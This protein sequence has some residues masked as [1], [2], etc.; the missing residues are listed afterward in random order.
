MKVVSLN[1][2]LPRDVRWRGKTTRTSIFKEAVNDRRRVSHLNV[3]GDQQSD[4]Q[5]H[6][7][8]DK[9]IYVYPSEHYAF[10]K[11]ELPGVDLPWGAFGE[12]LTTEGFVEPEVR[13]G[14][15]WK[16]GTAELQCTQPRMPCF[17]LGIR[18]GRPEVV[19]RFLDSR[20]TGFYFSV[21]VEGE[22]GAGDSIELTARGTD[23]LTVADVVNLYAADVENQELLRRASRSLALPES[24]RNYFRER[25]FDPDQ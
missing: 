12:N 3:A 13:I 23:S 21:Q 9:A 16:V 6:G 19:K 22:I 4:L 25:L 10:W 5:V 18:F 1:V 11:R 17:K 14:D 2:G 20:R 24:W 7:G 15:R 8:P